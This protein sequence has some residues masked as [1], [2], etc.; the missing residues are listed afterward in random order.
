MLLTD[1]IAENVFEEMDCDDPVKLVIKDP[2]TEPKLEYP[3]NNEIF[4]FRGECSVPEFKWE[5]PD[6]WGWVGEEVEPRY[7]IN[8]FKEKNLVKSKELESSSISGLGCFHEGKYSWEVIAAPDIVNVSSGTRYFEM[9]DIGDIGVL[10]AEN[11][12]DGTFVDTNVAVSWIQ[13]TKES[14]CVPDSYYSYSI[15]LTKEGSKIKSAQV[16]Y[17]E[18]NFEFKDLDDGTYSWE[19]V[20]NGP[21]NSTSNKV[22]RK[23]K[24]CTKSAPEP[25]SGLYINEGDSIICSKETNEN[26][27]LSFAWVKPSFEGKACTENSQ[28]MEYTVVLCNLS[29]KTCK[30]HTTNETRLSLTTIPCVSSGYNVSVY[31]NNGFADS[32]PATH[33]FSVCSRSKPAK[34]VVDSV[35]E[36]N[37]CTSNTSI[38]WSLGDWG[39][40]CDDSAKRTFKIKYGSKTLEQSEDY[41]TKTPDNKYTFNTTL[42][43]GAWDVYVTACTL[44]ELCSQSDKATVNASIIP[45]INVTN[46]T[47]D[48]KSISFSWSTDSRFISCSKGSDFKYT[49]VYKVGDDGEEKFISGI[50]VEE[51]VTQ[52]IT[53]SSEMIYWHIVLNN[54]NGEEI[55]TE[56]DQY[57]MCKVVEPNWGANV[58]PLVSPEDGAVIFGNVVLEWAK[59]E[60]FGIACKTVDS[61][62]VNSVKDNDSPKNYT[63]SVNEIAYDT[64]SST[65]TITKNISTYGNHTWGVTARNS[66]A[67]VSSKNK[68]FCRANYPPVIEAKCP[69]G[70]Y[71]KTSLSWALKGGE[72]CK[73]KAKFIFTLI[74][75]NHFNYLSQ[76]NV[77]PRLRV[78][79]QVWS[80]K[81]R[82]QGFVI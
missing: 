45:E 41:F 69:K 35:S 56:Q 24:V 40:P 44:D 37:Y 43:E 77:R 47:S 49:L 32:T 73:I 28:G 54:S 71:I 26:Q 51:N 58:D 80:R 19:I 55:S 68:T 82:N 25:P 36:A 39:S 38:T 81:F 8:V 23:F 62:G 27:E 50:S 52:N 61:S 48:S 65:T 57:G 74:S 10:K 18:T 1:E 22:G 46:V 42:D 53:F 16:P 33:K 3:N 63:V 20:T 17:S 5:E 67:S 13:P 64:N 75:H 21:L 4:F 31:A 70:P 15:L 6:D 78:Q 34:P 14:K 72:K 9:C 12:V 29:E 7:Y 2:P 30:N 76:R 59:V 11:P 79:G 60:S 66:N